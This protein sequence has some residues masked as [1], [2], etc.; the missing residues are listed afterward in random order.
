M[1]SFFDDIPFTFE[2]AA[3]CDG[4]PRI[5]TFVKVVLPLV[6]PG[7][8]AAAI[9]CSIMVW[10]EYLFAVI[11]GTKKWVFMTPTIF[12]MSWGTEGVLWGVLSGS[13]L[14]YILPV[15]VFVF[16]V[17]KNLLRGITFGIIRG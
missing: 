17:R 1:K 8:S 9:F 14:I 3:M 11:L 12:T 13:S 15:I 4:Y 10:N 2:E 5:W 16:L 7:L 6:K